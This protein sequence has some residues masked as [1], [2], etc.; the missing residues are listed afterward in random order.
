MNESICKEGYAESLKSKYYGILCDC[1]K[2]KPYEKLID[3]LLIEL[4]GAL[5]ESDCININKLYAQTASLKYVK[6]KY[7][8]HS[9]RNI[10]IPLVDTIFN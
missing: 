9:I 8:R 7:L 6:Y 3:S 4:T 10:C 5:N 2:H 1:E